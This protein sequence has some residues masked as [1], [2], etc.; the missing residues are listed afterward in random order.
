MQSAATRLLRILSWD[1]IQFAV[2]AAATFLGIGMACYAAYGAAFLDET[3]FYHSRRKDPRH[4][5]SIY[6]YNT[7]LTYDSRDRVSW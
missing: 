3:Y 7:Y 4:N 2:V 6:F 5:F 1:R